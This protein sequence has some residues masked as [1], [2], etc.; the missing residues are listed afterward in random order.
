MNVS[1]RM[2]GVA[3]YLNLLILLDSSMINCT[4]V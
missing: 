1:T 2:V 4:D 3:I